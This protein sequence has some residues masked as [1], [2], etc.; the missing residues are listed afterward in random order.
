MEVNAPHIHAKIPIHTTPAE[1]LVFNKKVHKT[2]TL[3]RLLFQDKLNS[4]VKNSYDIPLTLHLTTITSCLL[5]IQFE[6][7]R[8]QSTLLAA[9]L[10]ISFPAST[11]MF[12]FK[13]FP[14]AN[15]RVMEIHQNVHSGTVVYAVCAKQP[16]S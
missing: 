7:C 5:L 10:L 12:Q 8:F 4:V 9:S 15:L 2:I 13:A 14:L 6:L 11:K 3:Y 1:C 16:F